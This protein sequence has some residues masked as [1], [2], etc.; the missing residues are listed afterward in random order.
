MKRLNLTL[1]ALAVSLAL[2]GCNSSNSLLG[3]GNNNGG[4]ALNQAKTQVATLVAADE[5]ADPNAYGLY[6]DAEQEMVPSLTGHAWFQSAS[7]DSARPCWFRHLSRTSRT[8]TAV[9]DTLVQTVTLTR[10]NSG[11]FVVGLCGGG[12]G[13]GHKGPGEGDSVLFRKGFKTTWTRVAQL[14]KVPADTSGHE[15]GDHRVGEHGNT[16]DNEEGSHWRLKLVSLASSVQDSPSVSSPRIVK[17][18]VSGQDSSGAPVSRDF[19][20]PTELFDPSLLPRFAKDSPVMVSVQTDDAAS[21]VC[22]I[23]FDQDNGFRGHGGRRP[24]AYNPAN[25]AFEGTFDVKGGSGEGHFRGKRVRQGIWVDVLTKTSISSP[26][27]PYAAA[28]WGIPYR[29]DGPGHGFANH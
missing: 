13:G 28:G 19:T 4:D 27:A 25:N 9:G 16:G 1:L 2:A 20:D 10:S 6:D 29:L 22:F 11:E 17:V 7:K 23:H 3:G 5:S 21:Q 15:Q 26:D 8:V 12:H 18:T 14:E 24:L